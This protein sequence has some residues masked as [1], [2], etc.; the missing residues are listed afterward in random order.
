MILS[1][2][3]ALSLIVVCVALESRTLARFAS[4]SLNRLER[5]KSMYAWEGFVYDIEDCRTTAEMAQDFGEM[6]ERGARVVITFEFCGTGADAS[7][8][9][10]VI[11]A[12]GSVGIDIIPLAWT[13]P[14]HA[15]GQSYGPND[16]FLI[17]S[18]PR[19]EAVTQAVI[20]NPDP[21]LAIAIGDEPLYDD[22]AGSPA[23]LASYIAEVRRN[24]STAGLD[25]P[26]SIS[27][28]AYGWQSSGNITPVADAVDFF[29][30]NNFP[31][32]AFDATTG[33]NA[34]TSWNDFIQDI[35]YFESIANGRPI[36]VTQTGWPTNEDEFAPNSP[37]IVASVP[38]SEGF[39]YLLDSHCEDFFKSLNI[40]WMWRSWEDDIDGWGVKYLNGTDKW[41]WNART[42]C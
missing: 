30:V 35:D 21:V 32:F 25:I 36:L 9:D 19:I 33:G 14:I 28:L 17:K 39:W 29:M 42:E 31:Y 11:S 18:V 24:L 5:I 40:G 15:V 7:Y 20:N 10:D 26:L 8:Y 13:L 22:D 41:H 38:S 1:N 16:T 4:T 23:A 6:K 3:L 27:D 34:S 2:I 12:A 37:D